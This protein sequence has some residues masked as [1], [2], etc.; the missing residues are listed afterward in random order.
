MF[1]NI[2]IKTAIK[3]PKPGTSN[4]LVTLHNYQLSDNSITLL[5]DDTSKV[6]EDFILYDGAWIDNYSFLIKITDRTSRILSKRLFQMQKT[7][8]IVEV[9]TIDVR[10]EYNGYVGKLQ[11]ITVIPGDGDNAQ[12]IDRIIINGKSHLALF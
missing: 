9:S 7:P 12:Y 1:N 10:K 11:P 2:P 3:Y 6:G 4:P 5:Q 8:N